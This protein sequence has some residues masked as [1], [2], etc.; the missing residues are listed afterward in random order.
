MRTNLL[1][2]LI[3]AVSLTVAT[4][5]ALSQET[6]PAAPTATDA[7]ADEDFDWGFLG[8]IGLVGLAGLLGRRRRDDTVGTSRTNVR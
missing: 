2:T 4:L 3:L 7:D 5:P 6:Q 8:L 1:C